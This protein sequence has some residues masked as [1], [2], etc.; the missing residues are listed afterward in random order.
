MKRSKRILEGVRTDEIKNLRG[1]R[2]GRSARSRQE[3]RSPWGDVAREATFERKLLQGSSN[4]RQSVRRVGPARLLRASATRVCLAGAGRG[5][6]EAYTTNADTG[7]SAVRS[8]AGAKRRGDEQPGRRR[9]AMPRMAEPEAKGRRKRGIDHNT[10]YIRSAAS[11]NQPF[12]SAVAP[13]Y[14]T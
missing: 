11:R 12:R 3:K 8:E 9:T 7:V 14:R 6:G 5:Q 4:G 2:Q 1:T 13:C 10:L